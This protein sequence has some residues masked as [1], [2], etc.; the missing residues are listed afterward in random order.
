[1]VS[2]GYTCS[3]FGFLPLITGTLWVS[4]FAILIA[5]P[6]GL[7]VAVYMSEVADHKIR[8]LMKPV[9]ELLSGILRV[10]V[11]RV[12]CDSAFAAESVRFACRRERTGRKYRARHHGVAYH[13]H[14]DGGCHAQLSAGHARSQSG[15][16]R[17]TVADHI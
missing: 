8:N 4:L 6:F 14:G 16:W 17:F 5:L 7:A 11:L 13:Y 15:A 1:M 2:Y 3:Q 9:I 10:T 12:D